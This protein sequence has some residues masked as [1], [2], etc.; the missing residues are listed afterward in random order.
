MI[1]SCFNQYCDGDQRSSWI[2][3]NASVA[4][5]ISTGRE[6]SRSNAV[7]ERDVLL[8]LQELGDPLVSSAMLFRHEGGT[9]D[10]TGIADLGGTRVTLQQKGLWSRAGDT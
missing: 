2:S 6:V 1:A 4:Q 5:L 3:V 7:E 8:G 9:L 10:V